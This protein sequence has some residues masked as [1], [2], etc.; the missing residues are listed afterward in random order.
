VPRRRS[1][2]VPLIGTAILLAV[3]ASL[4]VRDAPGQRWLAENAAWILPGIF[5]FA[6]AARILHEVRRRHRLR[7]FRR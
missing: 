6:I 1:R 2:L 5:A 7:R 3:V 4:V